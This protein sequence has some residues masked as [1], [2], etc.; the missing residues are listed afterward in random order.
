ME[1]EIAGRFHWTKAF[2]QYSDPI[3]QFTNIFYK[4]NNS[5]ARMFRNFVRSPFPMIG[6]K[7]V[8]MG[9]SPYS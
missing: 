2:S 6:A 1:K 5:R 4:F 7:F 3:L 9:N 8:V